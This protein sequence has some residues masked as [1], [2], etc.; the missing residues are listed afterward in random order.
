MHEP[1]LPKAGLT[2]LRV[3]LKLA[4]LTIRIVF[5][6]QLNAVLS[7]LSERMFH[8]LKASGATQ[9]EL[10]MLPGN[11]H[12]IRSALTDEELYACLLKHSLNEKEC[13]T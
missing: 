12:A 8:R 7:G 6:F 4:S 5:G 3:P 11:D 1:L 2:R 9:V 13:K 10:R